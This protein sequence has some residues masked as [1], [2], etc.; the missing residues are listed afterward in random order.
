MHYDLYEN[1]IPSFREKP[2][3]IGK[4]KK[5]RKRKEKKEHDF[6]ENRK[7]RVCIWHVLGV[8]PG[9]SALYQNLGS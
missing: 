3:G 2:Y 7:I 6:R 4:K 5:K 1:T 9:I 8:L